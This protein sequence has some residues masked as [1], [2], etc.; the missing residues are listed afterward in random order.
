VKTAPSTDVT[1][2]DFDALDRAGE[3]VVAVLKW[4]YREGQ[5]PCKA[6]AIALAKQLDELHEDNI[7]HGDVRGFNVVFGGADETVLLDFDFAGPQGTAVYYAVEITDGGRCDGACEG[8]LITKYHDRWALGA[9]LACTFPESDALKRVVEALQ[10]E[11]ETRPAAVIVGDGLG[12][13]AS[14]GAIHQLEVEGY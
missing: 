5:S 4:R 13:D 3:V 2:E 12:T 10:N 9:L 7:V 14:L 1:A 11:E 8:E 6:G